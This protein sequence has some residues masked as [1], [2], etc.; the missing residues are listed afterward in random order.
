MKYLLKLHMAFIAF[1]EDSCL[2]DYF[3][4]VNKHRLIDI[5]NLDHQKVF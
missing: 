4:G 5:T 1:W 2:S 3:E